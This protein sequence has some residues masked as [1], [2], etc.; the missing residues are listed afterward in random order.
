MILIS[1]NPSSKK[2]LSNK[3]GW[4]NQA[5]YIEN[6]KHRLRILA[7]EKKN[8][9]LTYSYLWAQNTFEKI[10]AS[11]VDVRA[12]AYGSV[13]DVPVVTDDKDM[14]DLAGQFDIEIWGLLDL[15]KIM[16]KAKR[17]T[18]ADIKSLVS[19]LT[20]NNDLPYRFFKNLIR[21]E[22]KIKF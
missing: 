13:I 12:L 16:L 10:G 20:Y 7:D 14:T 19:Y 22:F 5:E 18:K 17:I 3:F 1:S 4:V 11:R 8:I 6:R 21:R 15:L 9:E 2:P